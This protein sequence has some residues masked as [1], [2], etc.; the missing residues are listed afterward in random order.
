MK[1][2]KTKNTQ[3]LSNLGYI[4]LLT[5][6]KYYEE[7]QLEENKILNQNMKQKYTSNFWT[8]HKTHAWYTGPRFQR[9]I[10]NFI[11]FH[12]KLVNFL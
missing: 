1:K 6:L 4:A 9:S 5:S 2:T 3:T 8:A 12:A 7:L 11:F 10:H